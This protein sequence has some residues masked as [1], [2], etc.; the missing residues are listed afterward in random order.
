MKYSLGMMSKQS[1]IL[2]VA[3]CLTS[4]SALPLLER[5]GY[6][7]LFYSFCIPIE[8]AGMLFEQFFPKST[9]HVFSE[10][11]F[12]TVLSAVVLVAVGCGFYFQKV[13]LTT[14][15][16]IYLIIAGVTTLFSAILAAAMPN[17]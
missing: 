4:M 7:M 2:L 6:S 8:W 16:V 17:C 1:I 13:W 5:S 3:T 10:D 14:T 12:A 11:W 15:L 9:A